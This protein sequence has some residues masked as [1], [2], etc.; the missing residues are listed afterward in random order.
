MHLLER[1]REWKKGNKDTN[2]TWTCNLTVK[3]NRS[4]KVRNLDLRFE[5]HKFQFQ[6]EGLIHGVFEASNWSEVVPTSKA[7]SQ[8]TL[9]CETGRESAGLSTIKILGC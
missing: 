8:A 6:D 3:G 4:V 9:R 1:M 2:A 7:A 5:N